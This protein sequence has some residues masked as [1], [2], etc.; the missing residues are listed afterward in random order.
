MMKV[1]LDAF[2][3][4]IVMKYFLY[5]QNFINS[6]L[7]CKK[8]E[9]VL[10]RF[11]YNPIPVKS[12]KLFP[13]METQHLYTKFDDIFAGISRL[14]VLYK[15]TYSETKTL[16][17][18]FDVEFK[19]VTI[20]SY[21]IKKQ[22]ITTFDQIP[23]TIK[24]YEYKFLNTFN[25]KEFSVPTHITELYH[26]C[27]YNNTTLT[28]VTLCDGLKI[29]PSSCFDSCKNL[30][31]VNVPTTIIS[32]ESSAFEEC[33][34]IKLSIPDTVVS[35]DLNL[36]KSCA[37]LEELVIS[38]NVTVLPYYMCEKCTK[39]TR[40]VLPDNLISIKAQAF[41]DCSQ[42]VDITIPNT[43]LRVEFGTFS[44]C[45]KL[46]ELV[47][48]EACEIEEG[49][50]SG[51]TSLT[52]LVVPKINGII[53]NTISPNEVDVFERL[54]ETFECPLDDDFGSEGELK[55]DRK[56]TT[57][58]MSYDCNFECTDSVFFIPENFTKIE[59]MPF[60]EN[61]DIHVIY[62]SQSVFDIKRVLLNKFD[63]LE[64]IYMSSHIKKFNKS[65]F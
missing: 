39:L 44:N 12:T 35:L 27:F 38:K 28:S 34:I 48:N 17:P 57:L 26:S 62:M 45:E 29:I 58:D 8:F 53:K 49:V 3:F 54:N 51:C 64:E 30:V 32:I 52:R 16:F 4:Q 19:N 1:K 10:D 60:N 46:K 63:N 22:N 59:N 55:S 15:V 24:I 31:S 21:D 7:T 61:H 13:Y 47:F 42:L 43:L 41:C 6:M 2:H 40:V 25:F 56:Y 65:I 50:F 37:N 9:M 20:S 23:K 11:R 14:V 33:G 36:F 18:D 5:E